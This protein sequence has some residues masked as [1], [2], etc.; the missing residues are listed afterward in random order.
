MQ[1]W[2]RNWENTGR[3]RHSFL[4]SVFRVSSYRTLRFAHLEILVCVIFLQFLS[5]NVVG[6]VLG[7]DVER[8]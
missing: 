5:N 1:S 6:K 8:A 2:Q 7:G 3:K 4:S